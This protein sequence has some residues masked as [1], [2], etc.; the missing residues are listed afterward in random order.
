M[1]HSSLKN[2][3]TFCKGLG[4]RRCGKDQNYSQIWLISVMY[5]VKKANAIL[6]ALADE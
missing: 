4:S 2:M 3:F 1:Q 6:A 5:F